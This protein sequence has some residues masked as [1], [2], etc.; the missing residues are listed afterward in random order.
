VREKKRKGGC[1]YYKQRQSLALTRE[2]Y[3]NDIKMAVSRKMREDPGQLVGRPELIA[4]GR[5]KV[6]IRQICSHVILC[7]SDFVE[8]ESDGINLIECHLVVV[9][10]LVLQ[11]ANRCFRRYLDRKC[12]LTRRFIAKDPAPM[13]RFEVRHVFFDFLGL[14]GSMA[15]QSRAE[16]ERERGDS[17]GDRSRATRTV[18]D[19][20]VTSIVAIL[21]LSLSLPPG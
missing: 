13:S 12:H 9:F 4:L 1:H 2:L 14:S 15:I 16:T 10:D 5:I 3:N 18:D 21:L 11:F 8:I 20:R 17:L 7:D 6:N 19:C